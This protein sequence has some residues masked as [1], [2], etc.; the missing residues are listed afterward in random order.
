MIW[1]A[2]GR[3][4]VWT[5]PKWGNRRIFPVSATTPSKPPNH[6][7]SGWPAVRERPNSPPVTAVAITSKVTV[8][9]AK[10]I[11]EEEKGVPV[12]KRKRVLTRVCTGKTSPA[13]TPKRIHNTTEHFTGT[14]SNPP[15]LLVKRSAG[16]GS[17]GPNW[18]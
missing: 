15:R 3:T 14:Q 17:G 13:I 11:S 6:I 16:R 8:P 2:M 4:T 10:E 1:P 9:T 5:A 12:D 18:D 7:H